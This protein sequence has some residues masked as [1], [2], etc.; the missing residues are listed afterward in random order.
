MNLEKILRNKKIGISK[1][2]NDE[3]N[4]KNEVIRI[5]LPTF[6]GLMIPPVLG[7]MSR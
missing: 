6:G 5:G 7:R 2:G 1:N 4:K 3:K